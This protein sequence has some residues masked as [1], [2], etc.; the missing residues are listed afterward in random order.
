M[1]L[2][3][4]WFKKVLCAMV[5][6]LIF[7]GSAYAIDM[8]TL[9][10]QIFAEEHAKELARAETKNYIHPWEL[11]MSYNTCKSNL[12][13]VMPALPAGRVWYGLN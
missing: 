13:K 4:F 3:R 12:E 6:V 10:A 2:T 5:I 8:Q 1:F 7:C 11:V 9:D